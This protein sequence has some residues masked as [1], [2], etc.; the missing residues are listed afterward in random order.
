MFIFTLTCRHK[1]HRLGRVDAVTYEL[2][3]VN[4][5][6]QREGGEERQSEQRRATAAT[7]A[8]ALSQGR[9]ALRVYQAYCAL[10]P[11]LFVQVT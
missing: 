3:G 6:A 1:A 5:A 11:A 8:A 7:A 10:L 2:R 9:N 4:E